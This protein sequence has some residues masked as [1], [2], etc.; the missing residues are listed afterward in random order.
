MHKVLLINP[1]DGQMIQ[2]AIPAELGR[3]RMGKYPPLGLLYL[4]Q[5]ALKECPDTQVKI[6]DAITDLLSCE[7]I[8]KQIQA[9]RPDVVGVSVYT[10]TLPDALAVARSSKKAAPDATVVFGGFHPSIYPKE[11]LLC[12]PHVDVAVAGE[13][14]QSFPQ[15]LARLFS[16]QSLS[17]IPGVSFKTEDGSL[18]V[19]TEVPFIPDLNSLPF[20]DRT[21]VNYRDHVCILGTDRLTTNILSSRGCPFQCKYCYVNIRKYRLRSIESVLTEIRSCLDLGIGEFF[22]MDDLFNIN[23]E[24]VKEFSTRVLETKLDIRWNFRGRVDQVDLETLDLARRAGC[25]RIHFGV[26]SGVP[27][28]LKRVGKGT[29]LDMIRRAV[30]A[31]RKA[32]IEVS[33]NIM[34]G[35][36]DETP[37]RTEQTIRFLLSLPTNYVQAAVFTPYPETPLYKE[38]LETGL[39]PNDYWREFALAPDPGFTPLIWG[40]YYTR[41]EIFD[42]LRGLYRRF[43]FRPQTII[44]YLKHLTSAKAFKGMM[45]N[46]I[47]LL[48]L[49]F[50]TRSR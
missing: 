30:A 31:A 4:A 48:S 33:S 21:M 14:E 3:D 44:P 39:L 27:E 5:C 41:E 26:E 6:L 37:E 35:L 42:K 29:D 23:K 43:Y 36:P 25:T 22:F 47:T 20:P 38:G 49:I 34:I 1:P 45:N 7:D 12:S 50:K 9:F 8:E 24:R 11:T 2:G 28:V 40:Q 17:G 15:L 18:E 32:G 46:F 19:S 10:F 16:G 13:A